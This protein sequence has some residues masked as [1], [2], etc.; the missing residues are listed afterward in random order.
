MDK[1]LIL[2]NIT[3]KLDHSKYIQVPNALGFRSSFRGKQ[4]VPVISR[5]QEYNGNTFEDTHKAIYQDRVGVLQMSP[6]AIF[7]PHLIN[8]SKAHKS[9]GEYKL[10][11]AV[12]EPL[13][14]SEVKSLYNNLFTKCWTWLNAGFEF[15]KEERKLQRYFLHY[16]VKEDKDRNLELDV[17]KSELEKCLMKSDVLISPLIN[18]F[19]NQGLPKLSVVLNEDY[20]IGKNIYFDKP[21]NNCVAWF[22]ANSGRADLNCNR[23]PSYSNSALGVFAYA[24]G[25]AE[26]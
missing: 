14:D 4:R 25:V 13:S 11:N 5:V 12:G 3:R 21:E 20:E 15:K 24:E 23:D 17:K 18:N 9:N 26:K 19:N 7:V 1:R 22:S 2:P 8:V 6:P 10:Y 16:K